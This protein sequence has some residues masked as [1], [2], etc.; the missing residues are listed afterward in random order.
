MT[1]KL[2][3]TALIEKFRNGDK[4]AFSCLFERYFSKLFHYG[5]RITEN[6]TLIE[7]CIQELFIYLLEHKNLLFEVKHPRS[8]LY[9]SLR[10]RL[11]AAVK[12]ERQKLTFSTDPI[13]SIDI[14]FSQEDFLVQV[15]EEEERRCL[16]ERILNSLPARQRE[17]IYLKYYN[18]LN[19]KEIAE[20]MGIS[21]QG[22]LNTLY[23]A[24]K[25]LRKSINL[26]ILS[27]VLS[28]LYFLPN[29]NA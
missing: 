15:E 9:T 11:I 7:E 17:V 27:N 10:Y 29:I 8:Y 21:Q 16:L 26:H 5:R 25:K 12:K 18:N 1:N 22:V 20:V 19:S 2:S 3:D 13:S 14:Q 24:F 4:A 28:L 23:K 6:E